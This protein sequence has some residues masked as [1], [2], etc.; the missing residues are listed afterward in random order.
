MGM[1]IGGLAALQST[2]LSTVPAHVG[3]N[4]YL[5]SPQKVDREIIQFLQNFAMIA[6]ASYC[7]SSSRPWTPP[8]PKLSYVENFLLMTGH[9]DPT[10]RLPIPRHVAALEKLWVTVADHEMTCSTAAFLHTASSLPE[11]ASCMISAMCAAT[12]PLH[13]GAIAVAYS[14]I[15]AIG[16]VDNVP[17]KIARVKAGDER[18]YGYGH[19]VYR[20]TDP[21][22]TYI[23]QIL[24]ELKQEVEKDPLLE[25]ALALDKAASED[26]Y[27]VERKLFPNA[28]LFAAFAYQA[29]YV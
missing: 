6:A 27:F 3:K 8:H 4:L 24:D 7:H 28:D 2:S 26:A 19:R 20:T 14:H 22:F 13:G 1:I 11:A 29:L 25:V 23:S 9:V 12:G 16:S 15:R 18:L 5:G 10:T 21:R 17:Q